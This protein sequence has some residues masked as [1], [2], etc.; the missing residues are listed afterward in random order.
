MIDHDYN[1]H[2]DEQSKALWN[3]I[4]LEI[5]VGQQVEIWVTRYALSEGT[6]WK[7]LG[8]PLGVS[9]KL[10]NTTRETILPQDYHL[11]EGT[12]KIHAEHLRVEA[13][14]KARAEVERLERM[15]F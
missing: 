14:R 3:S 5:K 13:L 8:T 7:T 12:A 11:D 9:G 10:M 15:E 2:S 6:I 1:A 4:K